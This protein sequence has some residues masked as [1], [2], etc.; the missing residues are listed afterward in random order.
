MATKKKKKKSASKKSSS[1]KKRT[2]ASKKRTTKKATST[3]SRNATSKKKAAKRAA[4]PELKSVLFPESAESCGICVVGILRNASGRNPQP[5]MKLNELFDVCNPGV[6][7][8]LRSNFA[9]CPGTNPGASFNCNTTVAQ[10]LA[11]V[12]G[13]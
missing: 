11:R 5:Q 1:S 7:Q 2:T 6:I 10:V 9:N 12:C 13:I 8:A 4:A 3:K